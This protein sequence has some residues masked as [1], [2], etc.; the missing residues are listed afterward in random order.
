MVDDDLRSLSVPLETPPMEARLAEFLPDGPGWQY[1]PKWDGFRCLAF[2]SGEAVELKA[3][4]GKSLTRFFPDAVERLKSVRAPRFVLDGELI[5]PTKE[6]ASFEALQMRLHPAESRVRRLAA[7]TPAVFVAFDL[8]TGPDQE[9]LLG[10][11]FADRRAALETLAVSFRPGVELT[12]STRS[13][14]QAQAWLNHPEAQL[15][16]VV[17][18]R[19]DQPYAPGERAMLKVKRLRTADCVVGGFRY[20]ARKKLVGS[21]LLGLFD[22]AERLNHVGFT[23]TIADEDRPELTRRLESL[24]G[25]P[26]FTGAAPGGH[27]RWSTERSGDW[28][29]LRWELVVEVRFDQVTGGRFRHGATFLRWRPDKAPVQCR[30]DQ[31]QISSGNRASAQ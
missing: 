13:R 12:P 3:K 20:L 1:E 24:A 16:G 22:E 8:L 18:K 11:S 9:N 26:G 30:C 21:L 14:E 7:S 23:S 27:S 29:S 4:S 31:L 6:G 19:L 15:D 2:R 5:I 25:E 28:V 17:C 10:A